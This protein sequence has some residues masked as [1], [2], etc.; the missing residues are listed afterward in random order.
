MSNEPKPR[1]R[2]ENPIPP[3]ERIA[4]DAVTAAAM[5][6]C[7][8]STF[9]QRVKDGIYPKAGLDGRWSVSALLRLHQA[10][11]PTTASAS[12]GHPGKTPGYTPPSPHQIPC[13]PTAAQ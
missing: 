11:H 5:M 12:G 13:G 2:P 7:G 3:C 10:N 4:V 6:S 9:F 8:R 1:N